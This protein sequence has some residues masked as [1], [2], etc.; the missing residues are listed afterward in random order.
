MLGRLLLL[1]VTVPLV[2]LYLLFKVADY[3]SS[4]FTFG[5][6][7]V[8]GIVGATLARWQGLQTVRRIQAEAAQGRP[9]AEAMLHGLGILIAGAF[10]LTPG[11]LTDFVGFSLLIP[12]VR[13]WLAR[14]A[15]RRY[16]KKFR[17]QGGFTPQGGV[18]HWSVTAGDVGSPHDEVIETRIIEAGEEDQPVVDSQR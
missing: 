14:R 11:I 15:I 13:T 9:P 1:F 10:L 16:A 4:E 5:L 17:Q 18:Y 8:T 12:P 2:E 6:I 7:I 3:T